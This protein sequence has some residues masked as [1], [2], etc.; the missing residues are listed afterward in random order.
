MAVNKRELWEMYTRSGK[1]FMRLRNWKEADRMFAAALQVAEELGPEDPRLGV[2]LNNAAHVHQARRR[3]AE[4]EALYRRA[5]DIAIR[6]HGRDH[7]D[8]AVNLANLAGLF[9]ARELYDQAEPLYREAIQ[10]FER[11][12]GDRHPGT[13]RLLGG[14][15]ALLRRMSRDEEAARVE[16]R[17]RA[18]GPGDAGAAAAP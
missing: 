10:T 17:V 18:I 1:Q 9:Q 15:A 8:T 6:V 7:A 14:Y 16:E 5:L 4:A 12:M 11:T 2:A 13:A 3:Y